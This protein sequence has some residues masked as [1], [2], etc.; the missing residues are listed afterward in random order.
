MVLM[1]TLDV[2]ARDRSGGS[3]GLRDSGFRGSKG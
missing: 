3:V 1:S 2:G